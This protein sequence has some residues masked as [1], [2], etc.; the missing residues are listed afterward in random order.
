VEEL[1]I[2]QVLD[3]MFYEVS[4]IPKAS[5]IENKEDPNMERKDLSNESCLE[6]EKQI[7]GK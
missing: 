1:R 5:K 3:I 6:E 2:S 4:L 7:K